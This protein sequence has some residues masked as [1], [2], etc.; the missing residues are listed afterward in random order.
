MSWLFFN[1]FS[2]EKGDSRVENKHT[3]KKKQELTDLWFL[4]YVFPSGFRDVKRK[5]ADVIERRFLENLRTCA[6]RMTSA[7]HKP[8]SAEM[9]GVIRIGMLSFN[10]KSR[11]KANKI[12]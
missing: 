9:G 7:N 3:Q 8:V 1:L 4:F 2:V 5:L 11:P 6:G 10:R 12:M